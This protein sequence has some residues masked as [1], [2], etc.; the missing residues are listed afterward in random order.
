MVRGLIVDETIWAWLYAAVRFLGRLFDILWAEPVVQ[1]TVLTVF[2]I[3]LGLWVAEKA[4]RRV[5]SFLSREHGRHLADHI[6]I[7]ESDPKALALYRGLI[8]LGVSLGVAFYL[9]S[10]IK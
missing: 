3:V 9:G 1:S 2:W 4:I 10:I 7:I 6:Q 8:F 5:F